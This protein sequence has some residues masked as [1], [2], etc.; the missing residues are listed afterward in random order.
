MVKG[1]SI[2]TVDPL[3][4]YLW[5][6]DPNSDSLYKIRIIDTTIV[7]SWSTLGV[8]PGGSAQG[9]TFD[10]THIWL[11][12]GGTDDRIIK[13][14]TDGAT[15]SAISSI[16]APPAAQGI[17]R[18]IAFDDQYIWAANSETDYIYKLDTTTGD[19]LDSVATPANEIRGIVVVNGLLYSNDRETDSVYVYN[20]T[21]SSWTP[22]FPTPAP[23]GGDD[24][25]RWSTGMCWD[26]V[27]FW[28]ANSTYEFDYMFQVSTDGAVL[29]TYEV[30]GR[31]D[32]QPSALTFTQD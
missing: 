21:S 27:N 13:L 19:I 11:C 7:Q 30:P 10:G 18:E 20:S 32:A 4:G 29:R 26:G 9:L 8:A 15:L 14:N 5:L 2:P 24:S 16:T 17:A 25:D 31:G 6:A 22:V 1:F 3:A 12:A 23:P 28:I